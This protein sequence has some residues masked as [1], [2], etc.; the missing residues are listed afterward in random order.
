MEPE[1]KLKVGPIEHLEPGTVET[2]ER[3]EPWNAWNHGTLGTM[4]QWNSRNHGTVGTMECLEPWKN[5]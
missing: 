5:T 4:E 3:L 2:M 1:E